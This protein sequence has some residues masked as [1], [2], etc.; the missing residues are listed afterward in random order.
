MFKQLAHVCIKANNLAE[1]EQFYCGVLGLEKQFEFMRGGEVFGFYLALGSNTFI[2]VFADAQASAGNRPI[3]DH[4]CL[5]VADIDAVVDHVR[6]QGW[7]ITD[8]K[9]GADNSWQAWV[10]DP[11]GVRIELHHYTPTSTQFTGEV[12]VLD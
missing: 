9:M 12:C 6:A 8:K 7:E 4:L 10:T 3:I 11:S 1:T 5:E 2:E